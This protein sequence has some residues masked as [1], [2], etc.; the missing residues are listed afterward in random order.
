MAEVL[1][2]LSN[3]SKTFPG[4]KALQNINFDLKAGEVHCICGENGAGKSTLIKIMSGSY[5]PDVGGEIKFQGK[6]VT[7]S[8]PYA[9]IE[10]GVQTIYQ[11][12]TIFPTLSITENIFAGME[13]VKPG[14]IMNKA[15]MHKK[16]QE[17]LDFLRS[18]LNPNAI[19]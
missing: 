12:H 15:E 8:T 6:P 1:Y 13:I 2:E 7:L 17:V 3:I 16:T 14:N 19:A 9:A 4:V 18:D 5:Q 11:E 10:M